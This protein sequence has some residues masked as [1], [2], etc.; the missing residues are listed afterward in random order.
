MRV[1]ILNGSPRRKGTVA[2]LLKSISDGVSQKHEVEW[3]DVCNLK[4]KP[5]IAC[6]KCRPDSECAQPGSRSLRR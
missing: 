4:M 1:L 3:I 5:C 2:T 6:M